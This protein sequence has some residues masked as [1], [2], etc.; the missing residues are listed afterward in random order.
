M[1]EFNLNTTILIVIW[2]LAGVV[3]NNLD[4]VGKKRVG[5]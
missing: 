2:V 3:A 5:L 4:S 1:I